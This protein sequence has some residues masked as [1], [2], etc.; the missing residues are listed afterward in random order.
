MSD[1]PANNETPETPSGPAPIP[2]G[3]Q[4][5]PPTPAN[6]LPV[7]AKPATGAVPPP[8]KPILDYAMPSQKK[9]WLPS[10]A[11][12]RNLGCMMKVCVALTI[13]LAMGYF[14]LVAMNP[15]A[16]KWATQGAKDGSGGP[17]PFK[18]MNQILAIPA[19]AVGKTDD[20][21]QANNARA[22]QLD[23]M[24]AEEEAKGKKTKG[25]R[26]AAPVADPF[27]NAGGG[28]A[29]AE[30]PA[31]KKGAATAESESTSNA[32]SRE[33]I[34]ALT[35]KRAGTGADAPP[36]TPVTTIRPLVTVAPPPDA[37]DEMKLAGDI[38]ITHASPAGT[39]RATAPFFFW[40]VN[41]KV[42]G[43]T[44]SKPAKLF[45]NNRLYYEGNEV[46]RPL[47]IVFTQ[48]DSVNKLL[49][50]RDSTGAVVTRSY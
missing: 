33:T 10:P 11:F 44:P 46:H 34:L 42:G 27:A 28:A 45:I 5:I 49:F 38:V 8:P 7:E 15:K 31:K 50:F 32:V 35:E 4:T 12:I 47:A 41:L 37:P 14:A 36:L 25:G 29:A 17:T 13:V 20:V 43:V 16:R 19:Q 30:T 40:V 1:A 21:V 26:A 22:A 39:P 18:A 23:G 3:E 9:S 48:L 2:S 24:I 6:P